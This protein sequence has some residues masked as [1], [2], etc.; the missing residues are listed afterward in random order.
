MLTDI[1]RAMLGDHEAAKRLTDA[2]V[3]SYP[4]CCNGCRWKSRH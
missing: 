1:Q 3:L 4:E 2:G